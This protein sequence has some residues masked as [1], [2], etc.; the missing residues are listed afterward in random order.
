MVD[1]KIIKSRFK[2]SLKTYNDNADIQNNM[3]EKLINMLKKN[4]FNSVF[5]IGCG[6]GNLTKQIKEKLSYTNYTANDI[7]DESKRYIDKIIPDNNFIAGDIE[8]LQLNS[9]FDL[10]ISNA[11]LQWCSNF[12]GTIS[13]L[14]KLLNPGGILAFSTFGNRN[15]IEVKNILDIGLQ[16]CSRENLKEI[17]SSYNIISFEEEVSKLYFETPHNVLQH[18]KYTGVNTFS[19]TSFNKTKLKAFENTYK[20]HYLKDNKVSLTYHPIYVVLCS[21]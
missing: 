19:M 11:C 3:A 6:T 4:K 7:V 2:K 5:E 15:I 9:K 14:M 1:K 12:E 20:K 18:L 8:E 21:K 17:L 16:Y 10:I 13:K